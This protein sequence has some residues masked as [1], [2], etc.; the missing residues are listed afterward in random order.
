VLVPVRCPDS[1]IASVADPRPKL[2]RSGRRSKARAGR[3]NRPPSPWRSSSPRRRSSGERHCSFAGARVRRRGTCFACEAMLADSRRLGTYSRRHT[4]GP[5][6]P[7]VMSW[8]R[9]TALMIALRHASYSRTSRASTEGCVICWPRRPPTGDTRTRS[10][11][12]CHQS[13]KVYGDQAV[14]ERLVR[15]PERGAEGPC[16]NAWFERIVADGTGLEFEPEHNKHGWRS[17]GPSSRR[18]SHARFMVEMAVKYG[19]ELEERSASLPSGSAALPDLTDFGK[20]AAP[21]TPPRPGEGVT[22]VGQG[23][24]RGTPPASVGGGPTGAPRRL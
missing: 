3:A 11:A 23:E 19:E 1:T 5:T 12:S 15:N 17:R 13:L 24:R 8:Q 14:T 9:S 2:P 18:S 22:R 16:P 21:R 7:S 4:K 10:T 6:L 20:A